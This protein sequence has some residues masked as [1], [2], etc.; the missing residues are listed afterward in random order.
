[1]GKD[2][3]P[4]K[5]R[6]CPT[7]FKPFRPLQV[8]CS[9]VCA[10][11]KAQ[12]DRVKATLKEAAKQR[13]DHREEKVK[14]KTR[15]Q[16]I[17]EAQIAINRFIRARDAADGC[18]SCDKPAS[19]QGQWHAS[20]Y[21]AT[22]IRPNLR[23]DES[24]IHKACSQCNSYMHG[25]LTPYRVKLIEKIGQVEMDRLDSAI[26]PAKYTIEELKEIKTIYSRKARELMK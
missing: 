4:K 3:K 16:W 14:A 18:I 15:G 9:A 23:F 1:M 13:K 7:V 19:W 10:I 25:N 2:I 12:K 22:S 5:C 8:C 11:E 21:Y 26:E 20:H 24:N 17:M 6:I